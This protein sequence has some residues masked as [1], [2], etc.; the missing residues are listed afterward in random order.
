VTYMHSDCGN[1]HDEH[2][3]EGQVELKEGGTGRDKRKLTTGTG[4][5]R[6]TSQLVPN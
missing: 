2:K 4:F 6:A 1:R 3:E 5:G